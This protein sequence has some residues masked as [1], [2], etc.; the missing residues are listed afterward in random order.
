[1][2]HK[3]KLLERPFQNIKNGSKT[4][5]FRLYD[6]KRQKLKIGDKIEFLKLPELKDKIV[7][8]VLDLYKEKTFN[9]LF[10]K[11]YNSKEEIEKKIKSIYTIYSPEQEQKYG[12]IGIKIKLDI[13]ELTKQ[14]K[15][16]IPYNAQ[17]Q[18]DKDT[19]LEYINIFDDVLTRQ[20]EFGH[21][22]SSSWIVN[23]QRTKVLMIYHNIYNSWAWTGGHADGE[24]N[25]LNVALKEA[26]EETGLS[27]IRPITDSIYTMEIICV[28]GHIKRNKYVSSHLHLNLTYLLEA[29]ENEKLKI[30]RDENSGV[31]WIDINKSIGIS[32]EDWMK[33][34]YKKI[35]NKMETNYI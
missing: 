16:Y 33:G 19:M 2:V 9:E 21:F 4:V 24:N 1:M 3:M 14:I 10:K 29:D 27:N 17:E 20:N 31:K 35:I 7:V 18:K 5:E 25:L 15:G 6:E 13:D 22:T 32:S 30:K 26:K 23:K 12:I 28:N 8:E 11:L 34:I